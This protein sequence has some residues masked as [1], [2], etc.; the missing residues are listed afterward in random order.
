MCLIECLNIYFK[1]NCRKIFS[2]YFWFISFSFLNLAKS[3]NSLNQQKH[4]DNCTV[5]EKAQQSHES[6]RVHALSANVLD[7]KR[8]SPQVF[9]SSKQPINSQSGIVKD[10]TSEMLSS[11]QKTSLKN[12]QN[13]LYNSIDNT[14]TEAR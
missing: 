1:R 8:A 3:P 2:N 14:V 9:L 10:Y 12:K 4:Y 7:T 5:I 11:Y 6:T 13:S